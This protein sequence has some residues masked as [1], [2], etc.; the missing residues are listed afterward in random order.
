MSAERIVA[1]IIELEN[2][3]ES[4]G[5]R[6]RFKLSFQDSNNFQQ[7]A[8]LFMRSRILMEYRA[9]YH[10]DGYATARIANTTITYWR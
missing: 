5:I 4:E 10:L 9:P 6:G 1:A 3:L 7:L 2:A 8:D